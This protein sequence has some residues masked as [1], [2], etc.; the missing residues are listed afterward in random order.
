MSDISGT[1]TVGSAA[2]GVV[3]LCFV[4]GAVLA[5][6]GRLVVAGVA[7][8]AGHTFLATA[9]MVEG[10]RRR[11]AGLSLSGVGWL[12]LSVSL[13]AGGSSA[14]GVAVPET[15]LLAVGIGLVTVGTLLVVGA[16]GAGDAEAESTPKN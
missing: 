10:Q 7:F 14:G 8:L 3:A 5:V 16:L 9:A 12:A 1:G 15:P 2:R 13:G 4:G 11:G 6:T